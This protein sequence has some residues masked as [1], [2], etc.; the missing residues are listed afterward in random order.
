MPLFDTSQEAW[1]AP[2]LLNSWVNYG[3]G[4][5]NAGYWKDSHGVVHLRGLVK[6]GGTA[7]TIF[8]LPAGYRPAANELFLVASG[9]TPTFAQIAIDTAGGVVFLNGSNGYVSLS[10]ITFRAA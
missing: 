9:T 5:A 1:I 2:T 3:G 8:T 6:S 7:S 4:Y 10:G